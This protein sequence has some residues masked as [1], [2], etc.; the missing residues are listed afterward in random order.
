MRQQKRFAVVFINDARES[1][2]GGGICFAQ[3]KRN[4]PEF[5]I[6]RGCIAIAR[7]EESVKHQI[8]ANQLSQRFLLAL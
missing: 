5:C 4:T 8:A 1:I 6:R 3:K 2:P 7:R